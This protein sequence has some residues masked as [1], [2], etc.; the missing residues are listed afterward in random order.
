M[1]VMGALFYLLLVTNPISGTELEDQPA[2]TPRAV[3]G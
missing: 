1:A 3:S 2:M